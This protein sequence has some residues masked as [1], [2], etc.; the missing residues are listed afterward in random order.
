M[1]ISATE[2]EDEAGSSASNSI[3]LLDLSEEGGR[4]LT[5]FNLGDDSSVGSPSDTPASY[6]APIQASLAPT[7]S[8]YD[9]VPIEDGPMDGED[10]QRA[11]DT[12]E[13]TEAIHDTGEQH[14]NHVYLSMV[15]NLL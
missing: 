3:S 11:S 4:D 6:I 7:Q 13:S 15:R 14:Q 12:P 10:A 2:V 8:D 5:V 1:S 9:G